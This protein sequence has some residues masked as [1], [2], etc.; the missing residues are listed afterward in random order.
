VTGRAAGDSMG[1][2]NCVQT[3]DL[4]L[5]AFGLLRGG[6]LR[7]VIVRADRGRQVA[8]FVIDGAGLDDAEQEYFRGETRVNLRLFKSEVSRLKSIAFEALR[9]EE[10]RHDRQPAREFRR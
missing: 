2:E 8:V 7:E 9:K 4:F 5:G 10:S 1:R 3:D 6:N